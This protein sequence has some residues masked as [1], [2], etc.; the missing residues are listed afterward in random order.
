MRTLCAQDTQ[1]LFPG[2]QGSLGL[3]SRGHTLPAT[4][5]H[6]E[7]EAVLPAG[8]ERNTHEEKALTAHNVALSRFRPSASCHSGSREEVSCAR[9]ARALAPAS[10][11]RKRSFSCAAGRVFPAFVGGDGCWYASR[12]QPSM[13]V[14]TCVCRR[15][16]HL[17]R[18]SIAGCSWILAH[19]MTAHASTFGTKTTLPCSSGLRT[20]A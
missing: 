20:A 13:A 14:G 18:K 2:R 8:R 11:P 17:R 1:D 19:A 9:P 4:D 16:V 5:G 7:R 12:L 3:E 6:F 15:E 10:H